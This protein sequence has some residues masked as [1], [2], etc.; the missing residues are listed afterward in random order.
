MEVCLRCFFCKKSS[1]IGIFRREQNE[2]NYMKLSQ[3]LL[4][5]GKIKCVLLYDTHIPITVCFIT[6]MSM[7]YETSNFGKGKLVVTK[8]FFEVH[9]IYPIFQ[10]LH[11]TSGMHSGFTNL[12]IHDRAI[13]FI[14]YPSLTLNQ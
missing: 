9:L 3:L 4:T 10:T 6:V 11:Y 1:L 7:I 14:G 12:R 2:I 5:K 8:S 13:F